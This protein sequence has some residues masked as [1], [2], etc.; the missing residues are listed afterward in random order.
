[1]PRRKKVTRRTART[2]G[3][4]RR[5]AKKPAVL[6]RP[7]LKSTKLTV[8]PKIF[9]QASPVSSG[10][11]SM[12]DAQEKIDSGVVANFTSDEDVTS[13]ASARLED[14]GFEILHVSRLM[15]NIAGSAKLFERSFKTKIFAEE[16]PVIKP[17]AHED[18]ATFLDT[19]DTPISGLIS[20]KGTRFADVIEGVAIEEPRYFMESTLAPTKEYW[21]LRVPG[22]VSI[23]CNAD[24]A[25]R[26]GI[27][28]RGVHVVM[29]DS[30]WYRHQFFVRRGYRASPVVLGPGAANP[31]ADESGHGTGESANLF[32][33]APDIGFTMVKINFVNSIGA[34]NAAV[35]LGPDI[36]SCSWGSSVRN[37]PL[38]AANQALAAA[39][40]AAVSS[41]IIVVF[42]AGNGH[43]GF[44]GQHPDVIS[45]GGVFMHPDESLE[46]SDYASGFMSNIYVRRRVPDLCGLVG[47]QP[48]A[49][50]IMLPVEPSDNID[51]GRAGGTHPPRDETDPDDGWAVFSG[52]SAAA[53]HL[54]GASALIKQACPYLQPTDVRDILR[55]TARDVTVGSGNPST[56]GNPATT[57]P[58][59]ATGDGL[60]DAHKAAMVARVRCLGSIQ[61]IQ[62]IR[63]PIQPI[64][65]PI[66][67][68]RPPI[69]PVQ[70]I[71]PPIP[72]GPIPP[73]P[74]TTETEPGQ[75]ARVKQRE[76]R[77]EP[78]LTKEEVESLEDLIKRGEFDLGS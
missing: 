9:A 24:R 6:R 64:Q 46:A 20:T 52:T 25:H 19:R 10:E 13:R 54:A 60:V 77:R 2:G 73:G 56:G 33:V 78:P 7:K 75:G 59:L 48:G 62:P 3:S 51:R 8:P 68:I 70:P 50:Y 40:A 39:V 41:G 16:R 27:S 49:S 14:A 63:P 34:F 38:S 57:G 36:I 30:G 29:V 22:D 61:P 58:D 23:G 74:V 47:M 11:L 66:Q 28:G 44:P 37:P 67:P 15:I 72:P 53:P 1:M 5:P 55:T 18:T 42:S 32:A 45:A 12:F 26:A 21:H 17:G 69:Q 71:R 31:L 35:D 4:G 65:P 43:W 76:E